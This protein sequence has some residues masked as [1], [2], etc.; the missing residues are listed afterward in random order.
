MWTRK[1]S[2]TLSLIFTIIIT[3]LVTAAAFF[4]PLGMRLWF[5]SYRG[6][7]VDGE[8]FANILNIFYIFFYPCATFAYV[9]LYSL[10]RLL[11][12]IRKEAIFIRPNVKYLRVISWCCFIIATL[13]FIGG[14]FYLPLLFVAVAA[15]FVGLLLRI[16]KNVL[17]N[18]V[19][20]REENDL[21]I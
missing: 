16:V 11:N 1:H 12:N 9:A 21:T 13:S 17:Q 18:A 10:F 2:V 14:F 4:G 15:S 5:C 20:I 8:A 6:W 3:V 7:A 19:E